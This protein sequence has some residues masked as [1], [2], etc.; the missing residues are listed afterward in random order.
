MKTRLLLHLLIA[1]AI[2]L[3][4]CSES[5]LGEMSRTIED[6]VISVPAVK[7]FT[8]EL[9]IELSWEE[10]P[11]A[12]E[13]VIY[14]AVDPTGNYD[15]IYRGNDLS[16]SDRLVQDETCYLYTMVK[17]RGY[18]A[19]GPSLS[20]LGVGSM[21]VADEFEPN[22][23]EETASPFLF[24]LS[25]NTHYYVSD[26]KLHT[27]EDQDWYSIEVR[28]QMQVTFSVEVS[29][30][31]ANDP[32]LLLFYTRPNTPVE[33]RNQA[34]LNIKNNSM[35]R[36]TFYF[37]IFPDKAEIITNSSNGGRIIYYELSY[38]M[39]QAIQ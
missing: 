6:P 21:T 9:V 22:N 27:L 18:E 25:A 8:D 35:E 30:V 34:E 11:G 10:D 28:P 26:N 14:R 31:S 2:L 7:S 16:Y 29:G 37:C 39:E 36:K 20:T 23:S 17:M 19:F 32:T 5:M 33:V 4:S 1:L 15:V 3:S 38:I 13:Y 24:D 12:D